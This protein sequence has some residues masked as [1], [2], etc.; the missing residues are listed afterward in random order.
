MKESVWNGLCHI[1]FNIRNK[2][3]SSDIQNFER[4][5]LSLG[6]PQSGRAREHGWGEESAEYL[7]HPTATAANPDKQ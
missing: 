6:M 4:S 3:R 5:Q 1:P 7:A 2:V